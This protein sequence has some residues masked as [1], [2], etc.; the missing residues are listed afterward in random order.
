MKKKKKLK[1]TIKATINN[2]INLKDYKNSIYG[3]VSKYVTNYTIDSKKKLLE[4]QEQCKIAIDPFDDK[5]IRD[6]NGEFSFY[7]WKKTLITVFSPISVFLTD[8]IPITV[9]PI[10][11]LTAGIILFKNCEFGF[12]LSHLIL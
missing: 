11:S 1:G 4:T 9:C 5:G 2:Q 10:Y 3:G 12:F 7:Q 8:C 6:I